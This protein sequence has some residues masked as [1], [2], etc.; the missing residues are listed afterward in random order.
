[1][2][3]DDDEYVG[4]PDDFDI[5]VPI[6]ILTDMFKRL[7][8]TIYFYHLIKRLEE[9]K[10]KK[11][12]RTYVLCLYVFI[13]QLFI[14]TCHKPTIIHHILGKSVRKGVINLLEK[15]KKKVSRNQVLILVLYKSF[16]LFRSSF[17]YSF[18]N[19]KFI[20]IVKDKKHV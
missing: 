5:N 4:L 17:L 14:V 8:L 13:N 3:Y 19:K 20:K 12:G 7:P 6:P 18:V 1:M 10:T 2:E 15:F 16:L 9:E 11:D